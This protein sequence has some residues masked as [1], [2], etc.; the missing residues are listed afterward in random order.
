M[1]DNLQTVLETQRK[2]QRLQKKW[3]NPCSLGWKRSF[4]QVVGPV[5]IGNAIFIP[6]N[7][8]TSILTLAQ[9]VERMER[10]AISIPDKLQGA[11]IISYQDVDVF[12]T[13]SIVNETP[14]CFVT[15]PSRMIICFSMHN[16][17]CNMISVNLENRILAVLCVDT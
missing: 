4:Q 1:K 15:I 14:S 13:K 17:G 9:F 12:G 5:P 6:S 16:E 8:R 7:S 3:M 10:L 2:A 11:A